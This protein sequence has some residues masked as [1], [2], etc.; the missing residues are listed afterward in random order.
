MVVA[1]GRSIQNPFYIFFQIVN[2]VSV[3]FVILG[4][5]RF[6]ICLL[7]S[8][9]KLYQNISVE[10][11]GD[12]DKRV[13]PNTSRAKDMCP[14]AVGTKP[15]CAQSFGSPKAWTSCLHVSP[16]SLF[17][18]PLVSGRDRNWLS[19]SPGVGISFYEFLLMHV[20]TSVLMAYPLSLLLQR[21]KLVFDFMLTIYGVYLLLTDIVLHRVMGGGLNWWF[22]VLCGITVLYS[23][24]WWICRHRELQ[25][26]PITLM[27]IEMTTM[28]PSDRASP[29][30]CFRG[31]GGSNHG[32]DKCNNVPQATDLF[33][34]HDEGNSVGVPV[35]IP[36]MDSR[37]KDE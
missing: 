3:F 5:T 37:C 24:T 10:K 19:E 14:E 7:M 17:K 15:T 29:Q 22:A 9:E 23:C 28:S 20:L 8:N 25:E 21:R 36:I 2:A 4:G 35:T 32:K 11:N 12:M 27:H 26:I 31:G 33:I 18:D 30:K 6:L 34:A 16:S 1:L 13:S